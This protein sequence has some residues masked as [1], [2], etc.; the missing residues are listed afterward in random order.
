MTYF[1]ST[2][3][4][5]LEPQALLFELPE[6]RA[7]SILR[8]FADTDCSTMRSKEACLVGMINREQQKRGLH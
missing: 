4:P 7:L 8:Q 6:N 1:V 2:A 3:T 5:T